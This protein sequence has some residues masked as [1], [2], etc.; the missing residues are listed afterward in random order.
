MAAPAPAS[1]VTSRASAGRCAARVHI[2]AASLASR[3]RLAPWLCWAGACR[4]RACS[5]R[6]RQ[7]GAAQAGCAG[8]APA[9]ADRP[10]R[11]RGA[12]RAV[13]RVTCG[14]FSFRL[15]AAATRAEEAVAARGVEWAL[16]QVER[17]RRRWAAAG[18]GLVG[19]GCRSQKGKLVSRAKP[20]LA[21]TVEAPNLATDYAGPSAARCIAHFRFI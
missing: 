6:E 14:W 3:R 5:A 9:Q 17:W 13:T 11:R 19:H 4:R 12:S 8:P 16:Q 18:S 2:G 21:A 1:D 7:R 10:V 20:N 15:Q